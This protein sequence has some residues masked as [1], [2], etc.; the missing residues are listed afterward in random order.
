MYHKIEIK[1]ADRQFQVNSHINNKIASGATRNILVHNASRNG[2]TE[3]QIRDDMDHIHNLAI[4]EVTFRNGDAYVSTNSIHNALFARTC[5]MSRT[6][7]KG[8]KVEFYPDECDVPVPAR[9]HTAQPP[10][11]KPLPKKTTLAN[12]FGCLDISDGEN[13][14]DEE[15][16]MPL[17]LDT[18][19]DETVDM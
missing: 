15:N 16:R 18:E 6:T 8:C 13:S 2:L 9:L 11:S 19:D 7:Y 14:S 5:M 1:W 10:A 4:V 12:R 17:Y 3:A